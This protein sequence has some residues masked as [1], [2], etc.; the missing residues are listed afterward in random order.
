MEVVSRQV[1]RTFGVIA[2][3]SNAPS[4]PFLLFFTDIDTR[5]VASLSTLKRT[6]NMSRITLRPSAL[7]AF[8]DT[9]PRS[10]L[11]SA[12]PTHLPTQLPLALPSPLHTTN[13]I[14]ILHLVFS[15]LSSPTHAAYFGVTGSDP[16]ETAVR[17]VMGLFLASE[18]GW[19]ADNLLST[20][21]WKKGLLGE[22]KMVEFFGITVMR[23][24]QHETMQGITVGERWQPGVNVSG[25]L[26]DL[27]RGLGGKVPG[28]CVGEALEAT[29]RQARET[30]GKGPSWAADMAKTFCGEVGSDMV[31][32]VFLA[33]VQVVGVERS[34]AD[35]Y[36]APSG[37]GEIQFPILNANVPSRDPVLPPACQH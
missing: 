21:A 18:D 7:T 25:A 8:L 12:S 27:F 3:G 36:N 16:R 31:M 5:R 37:T 1:V 17:G 32:E 9:L 10:V 30:A 6:G 19:G 11:K 22:D 34:L 35:S 15:T 24:K 2:F 13:L 28:R 20:A 26:V 14:T 4:R 33:K 23:E 29:I